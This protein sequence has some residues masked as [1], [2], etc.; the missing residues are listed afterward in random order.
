MSYPEIEKSP[1]SHEACAW[2]CDEVILA[3][4]A[5]N[6]VKETPMDISNIATVDLP[7]SPSDP[8]AADPFIF[9][10]MLVLAKPSERA[11]MLREWKGA[12]R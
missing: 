8:R 11:G 7:D 3:E 6:A 5:V 12:G 9:L 1:C 10:K 4:H 2:I